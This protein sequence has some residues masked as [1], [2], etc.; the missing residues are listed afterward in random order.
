M[1]KT[2]RHLYEKMELSNLYGDESGVAWVLKKFEKNWY[3]HL[4][5]KHRTF[6]DSL[7]HGQQL[8]CALSTDP[9]T[10]LKHYWDEE[11]DTP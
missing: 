7:S 1:I 8:M 2:Y 4:I 6:Y 10:A 5:P 9:F 11:K 3:E